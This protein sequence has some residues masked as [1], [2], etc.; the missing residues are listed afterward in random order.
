MKEEAPYSAKNTV[1][2]PV[3][4]TLTRE[5]LLCELSIPHVGDANDKIIGGVAII[6]DGSD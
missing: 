2:I 4:H 3:Y 6:L 1:Q 5:I